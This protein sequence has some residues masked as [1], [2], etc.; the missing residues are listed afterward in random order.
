MHRSTIETIFDVV[1]GQIETLVHNQISRVEE[2]GIKVKVSYFLQP[3]CE[4]YYSDNN[5]FLTLN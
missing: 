5:N 1:C 4:A 3:S 2:K